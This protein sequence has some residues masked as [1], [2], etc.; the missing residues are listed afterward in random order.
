VVYLC[1]RCPLSFCLTAVSLLISMMSDKDIVQSS[2][3]AF[4]QDDSPG[5][6]VP[7]TIAQEVLEPSR[8]VW[9]NISSRSHETGSTEPEPAHITTTT[10]TTVT[11]AEEQ[12]QPCLEAS[13]DIT[14]SSEKE[15]S[16]KPEKARNIASNWKSSSLA[17]AAG[18]LPIYFLLFAAMSF[19]NNNAV[20]K[21]GSQAEWLLAAAKYVRPPDTDL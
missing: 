14:R 13:P 15:G 17:F 6:R 2:A 18:L 20:L 9:P 4:Q 11:I 10:T 1:S 19:K 16:T 12:T 7:P 21:P 8:E 3:A 5:H